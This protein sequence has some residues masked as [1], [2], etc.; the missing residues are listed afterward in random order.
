MMLSMPD[1]MPL[2]KGYI[3]AMRQRVARAAL[4]E[5]RLQVHGTNCWEGQTQSEDAYQYSYGFL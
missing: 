1:G 2:A 4:Y 3:R 5:E